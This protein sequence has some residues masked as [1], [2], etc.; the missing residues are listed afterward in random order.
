LE[1]LG[2]GACASMSPPDDC[3][4]PDAWNPCVGHQQPADWVMSSTMLALEDD[5]TREQI[6]EHN[7]AAL[8]EQPND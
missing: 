3:P 5:M 2:A 6:F 7:R 4:D 1:M 8:Q